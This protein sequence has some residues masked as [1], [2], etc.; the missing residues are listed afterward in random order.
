MHFS[1]FCGGSIPNNYFSSVNWSGTGGASYASSSDVQAQL[2]PEDFPMQKILL[3][4]AVILDNLH[5]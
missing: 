5:H 4:A 1:I 2:V 3:Q